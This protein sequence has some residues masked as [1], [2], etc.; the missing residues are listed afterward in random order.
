MLSFSFL[1]F[2]LSLSFFFSNWSKSS[3]SCNSLPFILLVYFCFLCSFGEGSL[4]AFTHT[5]LTLPFAPLVKATS[6]YH[7]PAWD[8]LRRFSL[9]LDFLET[10]VFSDLPQESALWLTWN[11]LDPCRDLGNVC[12]GVSL[13]MTR[14]RCPTLPVRLDRASASYDLWCNFGRDCC[15]W[16]R[17]YR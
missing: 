14:L 7:L 13:W 17:K 15:S 16:G 8:C 2:S 9:S 4:A 1:F 10:E 12:E 6:V 5:G 3:S 11:L